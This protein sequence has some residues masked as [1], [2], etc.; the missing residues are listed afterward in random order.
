MVILTSSLRLYHV[1][2]NEAKGLLTIK[3]ER[4]L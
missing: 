1:K 4:K 2:N 3:L